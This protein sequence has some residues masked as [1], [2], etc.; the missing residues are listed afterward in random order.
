MEDYQE[1]VAAEKA[2]LDE[3]IVK[4]TAFIYSTKFASVEAKEQCRMEEQLNVM[5]HYSQCLRERIAAF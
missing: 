2:D 1:R 5:Q 4:L 3:K